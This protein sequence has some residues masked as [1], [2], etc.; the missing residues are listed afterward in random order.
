MKRFISVLIISIIVIFASSGCSS[1]TGDPDDDSK[2]NAPSE[3]VVPD[4][5]DD[6]KSNDMGELLSGD[7]AELMKSG[8]YF[9]KYKGSMSSENVSTEAIVTFAADGDKSSAIMEFQGMKTRIIT[10]NKKAYVLDD[11]NKT[12]FINP[13]YDE[14][15]NTIIS[16]EAME[17]LG[18]GK[19]TVN[20]K[21]LVYEEYDSDTGKIKYYFDDE[22]LYGIS[23]YNSDSSVFMEILELSDNVDDA[24]FRIPSDYKLAY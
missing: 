15:D 13:V 4:E 19:E 8:K 21:D 23:S 14:N 5:T 17:Y 9:L 18:N 2:D 20:G 1:N 16:S 6:S 10:I 11:E 3:E 7:Y 22:K 24:M 12:Y